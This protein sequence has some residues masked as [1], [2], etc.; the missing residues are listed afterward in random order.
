MLCAMNELD[1]QLRRNQYLFHAQLLG[2]IGLAVLQLYAH[3]QLVVCHQHQFQ[4]HQLP[5]FVE[6]LLKF[7]WSC[8]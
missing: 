1:R 2:V 6:L 4:K 5:E 7:Q 8:G 3:L